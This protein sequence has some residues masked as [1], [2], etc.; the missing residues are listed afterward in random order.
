MAPLP[1]SSAQAGGKAPAVLWC[2]GRAGAGFGVLTWGVM[3][4]EGGDLPQAHLCGSF[5]P[6]ALRDL[7]FMVP[8]NAE[9]RRNN[10][11]WLE[12]DEQLRGDEQGWDQRALSARGRRPKHPLGL[13]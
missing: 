7:A 3:L 5:L 12:V 2:C 10:P 13:A 6:S 9:K 4:W 11:V 8:S 1:P